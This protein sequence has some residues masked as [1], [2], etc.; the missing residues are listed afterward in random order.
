MGKYFKE[1][2]FKAKKILEG[3]YTLMEAIM[4]ECLKTTCQVV[5]GN[6]IGLMGYGTMG[7]GEQVSRKV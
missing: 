7:N 3:I 2:L 6:F 1:I 5:Q 4:M